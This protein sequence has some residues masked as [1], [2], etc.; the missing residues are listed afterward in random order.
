MIYIN[1]LAWLFFGLSTAIFA[2]SK[3]ISYRK[4]RNQLVLLY[5]KAM[6]AATVALLCVGMPMFFISS[7][8]VLRVTFTIGETIG[9]LMMLFFVSITSLLYKFSNIIRL[10]LYILIITLSIIYLID[11]LKYTTVVTSGNYLGHT[12]TTLGSVVFIAC[13]SF[14]L[15]PGAY[16][17]RQS[18]HAHKNA[19]KVLLL[20]VAHLLALFGMILF[21]VTGNGGDSIAFTITLAIAG[22][23]LILSTLS[24][25]FEQVSRAASKNVVKE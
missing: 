19:L 3:Y 4:S 13:F 17:V 15:L 6:I 9:M 14:L 20:G 22:I 23:L 10:L 16:L 7:E 18:I 21:A 24:P 11:T 8:S 12:I 5:V 2:L 1:G 25:T